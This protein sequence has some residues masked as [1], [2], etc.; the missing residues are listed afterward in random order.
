[1]RGWFVRM[2]LRR[3]R[4]HRVDG[5]PVGALDCRALVE[6]GIASGVEAQL[7][8]TAALKKAH[9]ARRTKD[10]FIAM[11]G[12]ELRNPLAPILTAL[13]LLRMRGKEYREL[14][15]IERQAGHLARLVDD[16]LDISRITRGKIELR[17]VRVELSSMVMRGV[18]QAG[19]LIEQR[20]QR[21]DIRVPM[22]GL[23]VEGDPDRLSQIVANLLG[24]AAR[25]S[26]S[27]TTIHLFTEREGDAV[28]LHVRDEG[29]GIPPAMLGRIF[30]LFVQQPQSLDRA[31]GGL[32]I[33]LTIVRSLVERHGGK[34]TAH[35][36]GE[37][38]GSD[39]VVELP[40][41]QRQEASDRE[42]GR[43]TPPPPPRPSLSFGKKKILVVDDN[44]DAA[45]TLA[46]ALLGLGYE[47]AVA[48]DGPS[49][50]AEAQ[51]FKPNLCLLDI[52]LPAM[53]GYE[54][55]RRLRH[56]SGLPGDLRLVA[57]TGYGQDSDRQRSQA[58]GFNEHVVK[59]VS[60]DVLTKVLSH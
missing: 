21:L 50:L 17:K 31:S 2:A 8:R 24:N 27:G 1:M 18:E 47:V 45:E 57:L 12:H 4:P 42:L 14:A 26:G 52:G 54:L 35:S 32:G 15:V 39:F 48:H 36:E 60:L 23:I 44:N 7:A 29:V 11:L 56:A 38:K 34:V 20:R 13:Q 49:A 5:R 28:R 25:Y 41:A 55:A 59:P 51:R 22:E 53:D 16:L 30:D 46:E 19:S 40:L 9:E 33:G 43:R 6:T 10:E 58:A 3:A 37:G